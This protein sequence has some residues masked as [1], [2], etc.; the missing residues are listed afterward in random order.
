MSTSPLLGQPG[1]RSNE[2]GFSVLALDL[3]K[4]LDDRELVSAA[5]PQ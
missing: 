4:H 3:G 2:H 1:I 5:H